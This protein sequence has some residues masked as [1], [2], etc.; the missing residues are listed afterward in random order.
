M[1]SRNRRH[2]YVGTNAGTETGIRLSLIGVPTNSAG[3]E[4]G[5]AR[6]PRA[7][8][9]A[10]LVDGLRRVG[11]VDD[12]GDVTFS[13]PTSERDPVS[14]VI[15]VASQAS[16]IRSVRTVVRRVLRRGR[17]PLV[18]GGDCPVLLGCLAG[19]IEVQR[20]GLVFI[21][22]HEDAYPPH[23]SPTGEAAD[24]ELGFALGREAPNLIRDAIG[25]TTLIESSQVCLLGPRDKEVLLRAGTR[26]LGDGR[27]IFYDGG[28]LR[29]GTIEDMATRAIRGL[30]PTVKKLWLHVDL[31]VL[32]TR[33]LPAVDYPQ[34]GGLSWDEL[35]R[36]TA[37]ILSSG[38]VVGMDVTI[39]NPDLDPDNR[40]ARRIARYVETA[41]GLAAS[42]PAI[43]G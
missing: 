3:R 17:F 32:S 19:S 36:L 15:A 42:S 6:A 23:Q 18:V 38:N 30:I 33:S 39:Y 8:R 25:R 20:T 31:D 28:A 22:G 24:M 5:V 43:P 41:M 35:E 4:D 14:G 34:P 27:M 29:K 11:D 16:M 2:R 13:R 12:E 1:T 37:S 40:S 7:L 10:G 9:R 26:S 21:D